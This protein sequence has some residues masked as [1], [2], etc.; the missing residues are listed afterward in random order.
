MAVAELAEQQ[1]R[2]QF[3]WLEKEQQR[4]AIRQKPQSAQ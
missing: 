1:A 3:A 2:L 4:E